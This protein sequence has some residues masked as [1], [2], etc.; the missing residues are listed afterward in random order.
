MSTEALKKRYGASD[1]ERFDGLRAKYLAAREKAFAIDREFHARYGGGYQT[2]WL[3]AGERTRLEAARERQSKAQT[4]FYEHL[5]SISPRDWSYGVPSH[6]LADSLSYED[7]VRPAN[8]K[9]SVVPPLSYGS[10]HA[11]T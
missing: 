8:E 3:K 5:Q 1:R 7:A 4:A 10:T 9:L 6:W 11:R 2:R